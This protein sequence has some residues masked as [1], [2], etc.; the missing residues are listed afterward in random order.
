MPDP[1]ID[2]RPPPPSKWQSNR[3]IRVGV[4]MVRT[5]LQVFVALLLATG[6]GAIGVQG[7]AGAIGTSAPDPPS[8]LLALRVAAYTALF[9]AFLGL[10]QNL[11]EELG[12]LDPGTNLRG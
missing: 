11:L 6:F 4:R 12:R 8:V 5:W 9:P 10:L 3:L 7:A 2:D 1:P